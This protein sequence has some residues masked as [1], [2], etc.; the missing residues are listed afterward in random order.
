M[1]EKIFFENSKGDKL[2]GLLGTAD[3]QKEKIAILCHGH[4]SGKNNKS[5]S[6]LVPILHAKGISTFR[7]D[8][9]G[10]GES[11]GKFEESDL[12]ECVDDTLRAIEYI[13]EKGFEKIILAGS[14]FGGTSS[15]VTAAQS[16]DL[17]ALVLK[18]PASDYGTVE[19]M[20]CE[21]QGMKE[22]KERG[23]IK[24]DINSE[25]DLILNYSFV[26]DYQKYDTYALAQKIAIPT[27]VIHGTEDESVPFSQSEKLAGCIPNSQLIPVSGADHRYSKDDHFAA[28]I[29]T[30]ADYISTI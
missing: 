25:R 26:E 8:F 28:M 27:L 20:Y 13:K 11:E 2:C 21:G 15:I 1:E 5:W 3:E 6:T 16:N 30:I 17:Y 23:Y 24:Y 18:S 10:N 12:S 14:S 19:L 4:S 29:T 9:Y 7:F 22:W